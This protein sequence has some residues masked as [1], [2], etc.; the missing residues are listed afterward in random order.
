MKEIITQMITEYLPVILTA[1]MTAI[2]GF[3]KSKYTKIANDSIKKDV[4][5]TTVKYIE[6]IY[7][8]VHGTE[9]LEKAKETMLALLEEKGI[10]ISDIELV[11]LLESAVK[12]MNYKSLTDFT[13][14]NTAISTRKVR[15]NFLTFIFFI[16]DTPFCRKA[17]L[18]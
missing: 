5:A 18:C 7:K 3:V 1:V 9:K 17:A 15:A 10:K 4:A 11:I 12:D 14:A 2:V 16:T 8:D 13:S 6:Q